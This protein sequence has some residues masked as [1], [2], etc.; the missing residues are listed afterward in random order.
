MG[1]VD[2]IFSPRGPDV[3]GWVQGSATN[4]RYIMQAQRAK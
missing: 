1:E 2:A 4:N 3:L